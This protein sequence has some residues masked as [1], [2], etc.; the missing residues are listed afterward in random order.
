MPTIKAGSDFLRRLGL[1]LAAAAASLLG[2]RPVGAQAGVVREEVFFQK[3]IPCDSPGRSTGR[4]ERAG[5]PAVMLIHGSGQTDRTAVRYY[6]DMFARQGVAALAYDKRGVGQSQGAKQAWR[7][8][9]LTDLAADAAAGARYLQTRPD[10][11]STRVSLFGVSQG[12]WVAPLAARLLGDAR[13][14]VTVSATLTTIAE[15]NVFEREARLR[16][17]GFSDSDVEAARRMHELDIEVSRTGTQFAAFAESWKVNRSAP[18]FKRVYGDDSPAPP[19]HPYRQWYRSVMDFDPV[20]VWRELRVPTLFLFGD[21]AFDRLSPVAR[22][23][24]L[25]EALRATGRDVAGVGFP[26]ADHSL[27]RSGTDVSIAEVV[28]SWLKR[29]L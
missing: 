8:F 23:L 17:E 12:G 25:V 7:R 28:A 16:A 1:P 10:A 21:P 26:G 13:F 22:N 4:G 3:T 18:W 5:T 29:R 19:D 9:N 27:Q 20:P 2:G 24:G 6:A 14:I 11:D 15:D